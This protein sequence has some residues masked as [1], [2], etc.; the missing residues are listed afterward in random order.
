[1]KTFLRKYRVILIIL[2]VAALA[3]AGYFGLRAR[4]QTA[5][6]SVY[7]TEALTQGDLTV[8][9]GA[10]GT[11]RAGQSATLVWQT[12]GLVD[13]ASVKVGD[14]VQ[15]GQVL[16][17]LQDTSLSQNIILSRTDLVSAQRALDN[18]KNSDAA[19]SAAWLNLV[20][21][22]RAYDQA[23]VFYSPGSYT[24]P[25][26]TDLKNA[27]TDL[28]DARTSLD[29]ATTDYAAA[30]DANKAAAYADLQAAQVRVDQRQALLDW[31]MT[32]APISTTSGL[33]EAR[34][35]QALAAL[36]DA[37]RDWERVKDGA[38]PDDIAAAQARVNATQATLNLTRIAAPFDGTITDANPQPGDQVSAG[39]LAYRL[40]DLTTLLVDVQITEIDINSIAIGQPVTL[41]FDAILNQE[42]HGQVVD[43]TQAGSPVQGVV[44]FTVTVALTDTDAQVKPGMT[45]A[46]NIA[47]NQLTNVLLVPNRAVRVISSGQR[48]VYLLQGGQPVQVPITLGASAE[49]YSTISDG[50]LKVG[51]AIILNPPANFSTNGP[52]AFVR[53]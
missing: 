34:Y 8:T 36:Q 15:A 44:Y 50:N 40:D 26:E 12:N 17:S 5:Q 16:A 25:T 21:A 6:Q 14:P 22:Q 49:A 9:V 48:V 19:R 20:N 45:A 13:S 35:Q 47:V 24:F 46:V 1:M 11:V 53:N 52:P 2:L 38:N 31:Y 28:A 27:R 7:Q 33:S 42:Y 51:D 23:R 39:T 3:V 18:L 4:N 30:T 37:R 43:F 41:S 29:Q 10:T 32:G